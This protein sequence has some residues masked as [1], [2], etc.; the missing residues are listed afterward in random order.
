[1]TRRYNVKV[2][3]LSWILSLFVIYDFNANPSVPVVGRYTVLKAI[4]VLFVIYPVS[5]LPVALA[6]ML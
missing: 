3:G 6:P 2:K 4:P 5:I 1:M